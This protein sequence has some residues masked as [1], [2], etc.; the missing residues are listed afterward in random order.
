MGT[1]KGAQGEGARAL[2]WVW[3]GCGDGQP[4]PDSPE[5]PDRGAPLISGSA[6]LT[7]AFLCPQSSSAPRVGPEGQV[8]AAPR[9]WFAEPACG[10]RVTGGALPRPNWLCSK[11]SRV[12]E[13]RPGLVLSD[14]FPPRR[15]LPSDNL[16]VL[17]AQH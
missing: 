14:V 9:L 12:A 2:G 11:T 8:T 10:S 5:Q 13:C 17:E 4:W 3:G 7:P 16:A 1:G 6:R 15:Q